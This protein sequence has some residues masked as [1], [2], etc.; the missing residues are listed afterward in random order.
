MGL[1][2]TGLSPH[3]DLS[4]LRAALKEAGLSPDDVQVVGPEDSSMDFR[5]GGVIG[6]DVPGT[7][8]GSGT[9]VPGLTNVHQPRTFFR[10]E[11]LDDRLGEF[12]IPESEL[13]NYAEAI[14]RGRSVVAYFATADSIARVE[15]A[16]RAAELLNVKRF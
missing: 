16:F 15:A 5:R 11:D 3:G 6:T 9:G 1:V 8:Y 2:V 7:N 4:A 13:D 12:A 14:E 10:N